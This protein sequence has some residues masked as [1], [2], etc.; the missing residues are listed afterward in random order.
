MQVLP[1][2][3]LFLIRHYKNNHNLGQERFTYFDILNKGQLDNLENKDIFFEI[4]SDNKNSTNKVLS[5]F[6]RMTW[7]NQVLNFDMKG[8]SF[9]ARFYRPTNIVD[10]TILENGFNEIWKSL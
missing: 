6:D 9:T 1:K 3:E 2:Y 4:Y 10:C 5:T 8:E 7:S